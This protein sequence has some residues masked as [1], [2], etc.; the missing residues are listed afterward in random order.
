MRWCSC[1]LT[2]FIADAALLTFL[3]STYLLA[4]VF[5]PSR[6]ENLLFV[7]HIILSAG[8]PDVCVF[9]VQGGW[10][11]P[12]SPPWVTMASDM[13]CQQLQSIFRKKSDFTSPPRLA[14]SL[15]PPACTPSLSLL[16][17]S[18]SQPQWHPFTHPFMS[19]SQWV[20]GQRHTFQSDLFFCL[21]WF[22]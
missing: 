22:R 12:Q 1:N 17:L 2:H 14:P 11:W 5:C 15:E 19:H 10:L 4:N 6:N 16:L 18:Q 21:V 8:E 9:T 13:T 3:G 7:S 20:S